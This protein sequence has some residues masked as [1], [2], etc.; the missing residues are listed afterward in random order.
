[1]NI[2][3][4]IDWQQ[5]LLHLLNF[6]I[7]AVGLYL[8]LYKPVK[9]FMDKRADYYKQLGADA[10]EKMRSAEEI[11]KNNQAEIESAKAE[12]ARMRAAE[13]A[14]AEKEAAAKLQSANAQAEEILNE[15]RANAK[16]ERDKIIASAQQE[17][18]ELAV[19]AVGKITQDS[20][21]ASYDEFLNASE[22]G[23]TYGEQ[24]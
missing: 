13:A 24:D 4:N 20:L 10:E 16:A 14:E 17:I 21:N 19:S 9:Q 11:V 18:A 5:I 22:K 15:A 6:A 12:I 3:L 1:M 8:L 2:P 23:E 7:L